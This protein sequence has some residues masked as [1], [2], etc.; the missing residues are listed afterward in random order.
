MRLHP[1]RALRPAT[2]RA[3]DVFSPPYDVIDTEEARALAA[4]KPWSF[5][6]VVRPE[7]DLE[8]GASIYGDE[9]YETGASNL[10]RMQEE[11]VMIREDEPGIWVYRL[12]MGG[13]TQVGFV[14]CAEVE[15]YAQG[16]IKK[17][18]FTRQDKEDDRT[19][20][21]DTLGAHTGPVF[22]TCRTPQGVGELQERLMEGQPLTDVTAHDGVRH[23]LWR[24]TGASDLESVATLFSG[25]DAFYIADG[26]HR[27][28]SAWRTR[29]LR[30]SRSAESSSDASFERF[31]TVVFPDEQLHILPYNRV[32][33]DLNGMSSE[34][35]LEALD[36]HFVVSEPGANAEP[37]AR[38]GFGLYLDGVW[39]RMIA[40]AE[41]ADVSDPV[42]SLD[43]ALLQSYVLAPLLGVEDPRTSKRIQF[44][45]GIRGTEELAKRV[46]QAG[47]GCAFSLY[48]TSIGELLDVSDA[49]RVMP[50]KST[51]FEPKLASGLLVNLLD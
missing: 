37:P 50:P 14:G 23:R 39:R 8:P 51:W 45:G 49:D 1:F 34:A 9:V 20:H 40:R 27:A 41:I 43:V 21:V 16:R 18:E 22:L 3:D 46:D 24:I 12:D 2:G 4:D 44:V 25:V 30:R 11:G 38:N 48:P 13:R 33:A 28:A 47:Q 31:L 17:H 42:D 36:A 35:F 10:E 6:H 19:R 5:L 32:V 29:D 15:D 26:H 7:I